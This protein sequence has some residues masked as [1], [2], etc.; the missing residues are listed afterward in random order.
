MA[1]SDPHQQFEAGWVRGVDSFSDPRL[2][3]GFVQRAWNV[4]LRAGVARTRPGTGF[5]HRLPDGK[6]QGFTSFETRR[7]PTQ[8]VAVVD[9]ALWYSAYPFRAWTNAGTWMF[10]TASQVHFCRCEQSVK[11]NDD[12]SLTLLPAPQSM[13]VLQ[14]GISPPVVWNGYKAEYQTGVDKI[15]QG[16]VMAWS[17][18]R[19][20]VA[21][22]NW[23]FASDFG[24]PTSFVER[25]YLGGTDSLM[26]PGRVTAMTEIEG[27]G[28]PQLLIFTESKTIAVQ[29]NILQRELWVQTANFART[30][31]PSV[32]CVSPRSIVSHFGG[33][34]WWTA[35]G[36]TSFDLAASLN[37]TS[38]FPLADG[39][40]SHSRT[41]VSD[42][43]DAVAAISFEN[44]L[45]VSVPY[46][47]RYN[48]HTW[49]LDEAVLGNVGGKAP[50]AWSGVWTGF[51]PVEWAR[52]VV[53]GG[54]RVFFAATDG[55]RNQVMELSHRFR[56]D[57]G[58]DIESGVELRVLLHGGP[59]LRMARFA[60]LALSE[61]WGDVDLRVD[62]RG[63]MRGR[64]KPCLVGRFRAGPGSIRS[65]FSKVFAHRGQSRRV[66]TE[67]I[68]SLDVDP[69]AGCAES[70]R[71]ENR[72]WG[73]NLLIRWNGVAALREV[74][75]FVAGQQ[76]PNVGECV[77]EESDATF[78]RFDG[79]ASVS[80]SFPTV[81]TEDRVFT[82]TESVS[83]TV[84]DTT[85]TATRVARST[86]STIA[87]QKNARQAAAAQVAES[88]RR[89]APQVTGAV[90]A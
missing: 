32:G 22:D 36:L 78:V 9:G 62:W 14:D 54:E 20:W 1:R 73:F 56:Q 69:G 28:D 38:V 11:R 71:S 82:A 33:L 5:V 12:D 44:M 43:A 3:D 88:L 10:P 75:D 63:I 13:L 25:Y 90:S 50:A 59:E 49:V 89:N 47:G 7:G 61:L 30:L 24:N 84:R 39:A 21:R 45:L 31:F 51:S 48:R 40:L 18:F 35:Q 77:A 26:A 27:T 87:A 80:A 86:I 37:F 46:A 16:T 70:S 76:E 81:S 8:L 53:D 42:N 34:W 74:R 29:S 2:G 79:A 55:T 19:L 72:D 4:V 57:C 6:L 85:A 15:P 68:P 60:E 67:E 83:A 23:V 64:Y 58:R 65:P 41:H 52:F 66:R 17:G